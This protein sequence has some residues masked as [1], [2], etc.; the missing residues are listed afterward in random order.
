MRK[1]LAARWCW[2]CRGWSFFLRRH[3][4]CPRDY[5]HDRRARHCDLVHHDGC[6]HRRP[7]PRQIWLHPPVWAPP[8]VAYIPALPPGCSVLWKAVRSLQLHGALRLNQRKAFCV[9]LRV[10]SV[11]DLWVPRLERIARSHPLLQITSS[12]ISRFCC[13][14]VKPF[15]PFILLY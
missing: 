5:R 11:S 8:T 3:R 13:S 2:F 6:F 15:Y 9:V 1:R 12:H 10:T 4:C 14:A 7:I